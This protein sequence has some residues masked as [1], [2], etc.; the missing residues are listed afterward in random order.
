M[1]VDKAKLEEF[2]LEKGDRITR[3]EVSSL[4]GVSQRHDHFP[5]AVLAV[6]QAVERKLDQDK[7]TASVRTCR[8]EILIL[9]D[10]AAVAHNR[11]LNRSARRKANKAAKQIAAVDVSNLSAVEREE[12]QAVLQRCLNDR[13]ALRDARDPYSLLNMAKGGQA[14]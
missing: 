11:S 13:R 14:D 10:S 1:K 5:L 7:R 4:T 2:A 12:H 8:G 6:K 9:S 3:A